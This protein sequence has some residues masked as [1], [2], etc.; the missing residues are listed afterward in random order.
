MEH[1]ITLIP[2]DGIGPEVTSAAVKV[3]EKSGVTINWE[4]VRMG[5]AVIE[6]FNTPMPSYV[7]ESIKKNKVALK[8]PV[9]TPIG[10]GFKSVNVTLRQ[11]LNLYANIRPI[12]TH[13]G[14]P[15]RFE[16]VDIII[17]REN[18]EDLYA[19]IEHMITEDIAESIKVISKKASDRIVEYAFKLAKEQNRKQVIAVHK[20]NIMKLS[21][22]LFLR[23][24]R[25][26]ATMHKDIGFGDVIV[27]A[28]S[29]KL[30]M[31]PEKYDV[32]VMP[33]LYGD[34]LS[35][36]AAGLIG[37]LGLVPGANI[38]EEGAVFEPAH[39]SAPDIA[40]LNLANPT[41]CILSGVMMLRFIGEVE[42]ANKIEKAVD[43][44]LKEGEHLTC[45]LGGNTG[46]REFAEAIIG[47]M[48]K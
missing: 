15:S 11:E 43:D 40:G 12:K 2:G 37:G 48:G 44:V 45:D 32:L 25:N 10:K 1:N 41:A 26:I 29:M 23:C 18:S 36:M 28:M 13:E 14:V 4:T 22:G 9:T 19:G 7:L 21:D 39:G 47:K 46:T 31:N 3:I 38:G 5:A 6:E 30:V 27:D 8:G 16:D 33:N 20:A 42:A 34:I 35:D 24:A 17:V